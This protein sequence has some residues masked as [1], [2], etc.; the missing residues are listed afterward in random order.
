GLEVSRREVYRWSSDPPWL[1]KTGSFFRV[2]QSG[3][4]RGGTTPA[5]SGCCV[6]VHEAKEQIH[7]TGELRPCLSTRGASGI[8]RAANYCSRSEFGRTATTA[9][10]GARQTTLSHLNSKAA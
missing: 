7:L 9:I 8:L 5:V 3:I 10:L 6:A 1:A 2:H 4:R